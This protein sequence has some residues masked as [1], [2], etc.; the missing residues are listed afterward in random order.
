MCNHTW[1]YAGEPNVTLDV[2]EGTIDIELEVNR[3]VKCNEVRVFVADSTFSSYE[4]IRKLRKLQ[5]ELQM[6]RG[7]PPYDETPISPPYDR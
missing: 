4:D 7:R 6:K 3:C 1:E 5:E 2:G